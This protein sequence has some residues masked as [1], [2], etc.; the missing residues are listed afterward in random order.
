MM[1]AQ[2]K[3]D[4][5]T[6]A[7]D[8]FDEVK[9]CDEHLIKVRESHDDLWTYVWETLAGGQFKWVSGTYEEWDNDEGACT[10]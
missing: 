3:R 7:L 10:G 5:L 2:A 1:L 8:N 9:V 4:L 6:M